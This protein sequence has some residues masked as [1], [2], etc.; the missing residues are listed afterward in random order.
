MAQVARLERQLA[1]NEAQRQQAEVQG[2]AERNAALRAIETEM[3]AQLAAARGESIG[4]S[5]QVHLAC[6]SPP[7][8]NLQPRAAT[9]P[10]PPHRP[11]HPVNYP[12]Q[13]AVGEQ[14]VQLE[15]ALRH[16]RQEAAQLHGG[17]ARAQADRQ[18]LER[19]L[20]ATQAEAAQAV[21][22]RN[23]AL[24]ERDAALRERCGPAH[25]LSLEG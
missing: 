2:A 15:G 18:A 19:A 11:T 17:E 25:R 16:A 6:P 8:P 24:S 12:G 1:Q 4:L 7:T 3:H 22:Q 20:T 23:A 14:V 9:S 10:R 13:Y 5:E 21:A